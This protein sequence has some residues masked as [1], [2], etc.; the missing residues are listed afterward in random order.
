MIPSRL[1]IAGAALA[2]FLLPVGPAA[3]ADPLAVRAHAVSLPDLDGAPGTV[4]LLSVPLS[5]ASFRYYATVT[6]RGGSGGTESR[7]WV[8]DAATDRGAVE[9]GEIRRLDVFRLPPG[10]LHA[11]IRVEGLDADVEADVRLEVFVPDF[12][13]PGLHLSDLVLGSCT[14]A[15]RGEERDAGG[16]WDTVT[17][18]AAPRFGHANPDLCAWAQVTDTSPHLA[19]SVYAVRTR[20]QKDRGKTVLEVLSTARRADGKGVVRLHPSIESLTQ[21]DYVLEVEVSLGAD[22][23]RSEAG[24]A[25]DESR[26]A[27]REDPDKL[28][29]ILAYVATNRELID[30]EQTSRDSLGAFWERFWERRDPDPRTETNEALAEFLGRVDFASLHFGT[31]EPGWRTDRGRIYIQYGPPDREERVASD[32]SGLPTLL[33]SYYDRHLTFVFQDP[34]GFGGYRLAGQRRTQG[35]S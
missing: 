6:F 9:R 22:R 7:D 19:D 13:E 14:D 16:P 23:A 2:G 11:R 31:L 24:F 26:F 20:I 30:L 5:G 29:E 27:L 21:G 28:R 15:T 35:R 34:K 4:L 10:K 25:V 33:W 1:R 8:I 18:L 32:P 12:G 17:L 3:G